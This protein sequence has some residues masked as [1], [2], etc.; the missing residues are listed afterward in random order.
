MPRPKGLTVVERKFARLRAS[1]V[2]QGEAMRQAKDAD[3]MT[4]S[5]SSYA[6]TVEKR[7]IV[8]AQIASLKKNYA[9]ADLDSVGEAWSDLRALLDKST[10]KENY[11]AAAALMRQR[12]QGLGALKDHVTIVSQTTDKALIERMTDGNTDKAAELRKLLQTDTFDD[13][14]IH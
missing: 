9:I 2:P 1:G 5:L 13:D 11:N 7:A 8:Q 10:D 3:E 4:S 6:C 12:L 14:S